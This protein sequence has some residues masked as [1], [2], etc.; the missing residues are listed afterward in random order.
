[1]CALGFGAAN[2]GLCAGPTGGFRAL[3]SGQQVSAQSR[4]LQFAA[5]ESSRWPNMVSNLGPD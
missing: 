2:G 5:R 1:M 4:Q 3:R